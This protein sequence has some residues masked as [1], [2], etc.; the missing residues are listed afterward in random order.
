VPTGEQATEEMASAKS[1]AA[2]TPARQSRP[3]TVRRRPVALPPA[4]FDD[5]AEAASHLVRVAGILLIVDGYNVTMASWPNLEL[6]R[7]RH[8]LVD[9]LAELAMR[10]GTLVQVVFDGADVAGRFGAP[11]AA[12]RLM[13][14]TFSPEGIEADQVIMDLVDRLDPGQAVVV[15][16]N[17]R[18]LQEGVRRRG[19]NVITVAQLLAVIGRTGDASGG[20]MRWPRSRQRRGQG[21]GY[22]HAVLAG[23]DYE[24]RHGR[25]RPGGRPL[26]HRAP[27]G[28]GRGGDLRRHTVRRYPAHAPRPP[29]AG[30]GG[31]HAVH[32]PK[33]GPLH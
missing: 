6:S 27:G 28:T 24:G 22:R 20:G 14:V 15:A 32:L 16:T 31:R 7:Q 4:V 13:R 30:L 10:A 1:R 12:R 9:A 23:G 18:R 29:G 17:D 5:S 25:R 19:G 2:A 26:Q 8:Q 33:P 11:P 3:L 21:A